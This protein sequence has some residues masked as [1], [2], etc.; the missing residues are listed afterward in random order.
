MAKGFPESTVRTRPACEDLSLRHSRP[1]A[2]FDSEALEDFLGEE[3]VDAT[4]SPIGTL[5]CFW[6][7]EDGKPVL[8][9][10]D[11]GALSNGT[12]LLPAKGAQLNTN[13]SYVAVDFTK[14]KVRKAP[15]LD[16]GSELNPK[17]EKKVFAYY[18]ASAL[19]YEAVDVDSG[20]ALR[21]KNHVASK[22]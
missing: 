10:I 6:E 9:G 11:I 20:R 13:K 8:L 18:G 15:A 3:V 19:D 12:H 7:H 21:R 4:G 5:A 1:M 14:E 2:E 22:S 17:L 16:C